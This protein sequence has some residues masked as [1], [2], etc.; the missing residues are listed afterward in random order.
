MPRE[1]LP[2]FAQRIGD[3]LPFTYAV[4]AIREA[5]TA[6]TVDWPALGVLAAVTV[7]AIAVALRTFRWESR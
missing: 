1:S 5:W 7:G 3:F 6:G 4:Q 2:D